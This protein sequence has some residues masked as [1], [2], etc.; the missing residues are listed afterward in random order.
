MFKR[1][2]INFLFI[3][4]FPIYGIGNYISAAKSPSTGYLISISLHLIIILFYCIDLLYKREL[5]FRLNAY[6]FLM[7]LFI[8]SSAASLFIALGNGLPE[9]T[10]R[11]TITKSLL[12]IV[13]FQSFIIVVL[14]N[15]KKETLLRLT[16]LSLS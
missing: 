15:E 14:Y 7:L 5:K 12:L 6:Y 2:I 13:P 16:L 10:L 8:L 9:S 3:I 4:S 11:L 1:D